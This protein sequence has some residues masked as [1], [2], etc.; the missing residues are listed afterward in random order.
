[1]ISISCLHI[2]TDDK[3]KKKPKLMKSRETHKCRS[4]HA[5]YK[6]SLN[7]SDINRM[8]FAVTGFPGISH[9]SVDVS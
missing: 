7:D 3:L 4:F 2:Q 8:A 6:E 5:G 9:P 1:M